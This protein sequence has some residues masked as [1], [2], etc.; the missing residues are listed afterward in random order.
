MK[1]FGKILFITTLLL[2][3]GYSQEPTIFPLNIE[4]LEE[5]HGIIYSKDLDKP[6]S[7]PVFSLHK[8]GKIDREGSYLNG[9]KHGLWI[10]YWSNGNKQFE[11]NYIDGKE[12]GLITNWYE[13][14][15]SK[16][17]EFFYDSS[18]ISIDYIFYYENGNKN[19]EGTFIKKI[20]S[21]PYITDYWIFVDIGK[22]IIYNLDGS[23]KLIEDCDKG[24]CEEEESSD[25]DIW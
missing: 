6:Y 12:H 11:G 2:I 5:R 7:G 9:L 8:N 1:T 25:E 3:V 13:T 15:G 22:R 18:K 20:G 24:E 17:Q 21:D 16:F 19:V 14:G 23:I 4:T 10:G